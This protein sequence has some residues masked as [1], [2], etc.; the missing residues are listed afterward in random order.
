MEVIF[1]KTLSKF[2]TKTKVVRLD[3]SKPTKS[4]ILIRTFC[5]L[6]PFEIFSF[7]FPKKGC[8]H[9]RLSNTMVVF[10]ANTP[11]WI[12]MKEILLQQVKKIDNLL[13]STEKRFKKFSLYVTIAFGI[14]SIIYVSPE[15]DNRIKTENVES[16]ASKFFIGYKFLES[17]NESTRIRGANNLYNLANKSLDYQEDVCDVLCEQ[18]RKITSNPAYQ[19]MYKEKP[20]VEIQNIIDLLFKS[21]WINNIL[22][23]YDKNLTGTYLSGA[24]FY[25]RKVKNVDFSN[26]EL[27]E[28]DFADAELNNV[29]FTNAEFQN[30]NFKSRGGYQYSDMHSNN[31]QNT[32]LSDI[33]FLEARLYNVDFSDAILNAVDFESAKLI[34]VNLRNYMSNSSPSDYKRF[35]D[36]NFSGTILEGYGYNKITENRFTLEL[37]REN[38]Q[39][40]K[41]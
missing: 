41:E 19:K 22:D 24:N 31:Y 4:N 15:I 34:N 12:R 17:Q 2:I 11:V 10:G 36:V 26:A 6:I 27:R 1:Q 35:S 32:R 8:F 14:L 23:Q 33:Y 13:F 25:R 3:G 7:L 39:E 28:V 37:T 21:Y 9:D 5:R 30:V 40:T 38:I 29:N 18:F 16:D 20:S